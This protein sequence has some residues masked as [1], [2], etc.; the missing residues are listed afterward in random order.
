[1]YP[2]TFLSIPKDPMTA[3]N[4][5]RAVRRIMGV[6]IPSAPTKYSTFMLGIQLYF[7]TNWNALTVLIPA[8]VRS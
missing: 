6:E 1:M 3:R 5:S 4:D 7:S 2:R 8:M